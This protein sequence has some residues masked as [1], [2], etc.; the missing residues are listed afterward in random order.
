MPEGRTWLGLI[1]TNQPDAK[2]DAFPFGLPHQPLG[3]LDV[4]LLDAAEQDAHVVTLN[5][6]EVARVLTP[7][8]T[9]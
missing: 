1:D 7:S 3:A 9:G 6:R 5:D 8:P 2:L 4:G